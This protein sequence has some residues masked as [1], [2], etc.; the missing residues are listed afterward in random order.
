MPCAAENPYGALSSNDQIHSPLLDDAAVHGL[1][2]GLPNVV[3]GYNATSDITNVLT[4][5]DRL[6]TRIV[7]G[8]IRIYGPRVARQTLGLNPYTNNIS[9]GNAPRLFT[10]TPFARAL[11]NVTS[12]WTVIGIVINAGVDFYKYE[13]GEYNQQEFGAALLFDASTTILSAAL[14]GFVAGAIAG[15]IAG[16]PALGIGAIPGAV[17]GGIVGAV[18]GI[19]AALA[20]NYYARDWYIDTASHGGDWLAKLLGQ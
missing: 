3:N 19:G 17:I 6:S 4:A 20:V 8:Q 15:F 10:Q 13:T 2:S 18:V 7:G 14:G 9:I 11:S 5:G 12:W 16:T 1:L